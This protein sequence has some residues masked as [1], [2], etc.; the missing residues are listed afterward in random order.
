VGKIDESPIP[1][2]V[3]SVRLISSH[4]MDLYILLQILLIK[5]HKKNKSSDT[6]II[7][8]YSIEYTG[9]ARIEVIS[10]GGVVELYN[11]IEGYNAFPFHFYQTLITI[12]IE[13]SSYNVTCSYN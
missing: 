8:S 1:T 3:Y 4:I 10:V 11:L 2:R 5:Y 12:L 13:V 7:S 9:K 6:H